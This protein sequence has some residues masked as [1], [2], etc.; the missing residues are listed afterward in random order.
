MKHFA[1][2]RTRLGGIQRGLTRANESTLDS[3]SSMT[4]DSVARPPLRDSIGGSGG[5][6][7]PTF[8]LGWRS[9]GRS[10]EMLCLTTQIHFWQVSR[11]CSL[12]NR[13]GE[14]LH[15][16]K[17]GMERNEDVE[18]TTGMSDAPDP[19]EV[20]SCR[21]KWSLLRILQIYCTFMQGRWRV[22]G[23]KRSRNCGRETPGSDH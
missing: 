17:H 18:D 2:S 23:Y 14:A 9:D 6:T 13:C 12:C 19:G 11:S 16:G 8:H 20:R 21:E 1:C 10:R 7:Y 5:S 22:E 4:A 15:C 3:T